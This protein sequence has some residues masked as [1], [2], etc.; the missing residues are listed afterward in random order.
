MH[1]EITSDRL[2][3]EMNF[4]KTILDS[5]S[6]H[7]ALKHILLVTSNRMSSEGRLRLTGT[8]LDHTLHCETEV[9][10]LEPGSCC[11]IGR[12]LSDF[13]STLPSGKTVTIRTAGNGRAEV[14]CEN[15]HFQIAGIPVADFPETTC[16]KMESSRVTL[17]SERLRK[18]IVR[19]MFAITLEESRYTLSGALLSLTS[20]LDRMVTTD[21][22]RLALV[23]ANGMNRTGLAEM[24]ALIPRKTLSELLRLTQSDKGEVLVCLSDNDIHFQIGS[25]QL[26]SRLLS[27]TFPAWEQIIPQE[28]KHSAV[29]MAGAL[30]D[31]LKRV[32]LMT[33]DRSAGANF[34]FAKGE[35]H[36]HAQHPE[37]GE[38]QERVEIEQYAGEELD[39]RLN[40]NYI[41]DV[42]GALSPG[43]VIE[44]Q[45]NDAQSP[46]S[47]RPLGESGMSYQ[48]ITMPMR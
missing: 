36:L 34:H 31:A 11:L 40:V 47:I 30:S 28:H 22:H 12:R 37:A 18:M 20:Q 45:L 33:D 42:L 29:V 41:L 21:G 48:V 43:D 2:R 5:H 17:S 24:T 27:G 1:L 26:T 16:T 4:I 10:V 8:D 6:K 15:S 38:A 9:K 25:R 32:A 19:T 14:I 35:L 46:V 39:I 23:Q 3:T 13:A 44:F 7:P